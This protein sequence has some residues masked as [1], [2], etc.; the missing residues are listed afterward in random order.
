MRKRTQKGMVIIVYIFKSN[1][2]CGNFLK[3]D[4]DYARR[5]L[6]E[7]KSECEQI[8]DK[9]LPALSEELFS[10]YAKTGKRIN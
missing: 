8:K 6:S 7:L 10:Q 5:Y 1:L 4:S 3:S 9:P 2:S